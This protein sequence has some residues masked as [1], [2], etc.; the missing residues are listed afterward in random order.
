MQL[1]HCTLLLEL[2]T[3]WN[4]LLCLQWRKYNQY[5]IYLPQLLPRTAKAAIF[6]FR[7]KMSG[8]GN[9][10]T[11]QSPFGV[12]SMSICS[13]LSLTCW[14]MQNG[15]MAKHKTIKKKKYIADN[16][17]L[18][19]KIKCFL[20]IHLHFCKFPGNDK[21]C[22]CSCL[23]DYFYGQILVPSSPGPL[24]FP[25]LFTLSSWV[26]PALVLH[27][28]SSSLSSSVGSEEI[29]LC[30]PGVKVHLTSLTACIH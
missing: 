12:V 19:N 11:L 25:F 14:P 15:K 29:W 30:Q 5:A 16:A 8:G 9:M 17:Q 6:S 1:S 26:T 18:K 10:E 20:Y 13:V 21:P 23:V 3:I 2:H 27:S 7:R 4:V 28:S 24:V 22:N